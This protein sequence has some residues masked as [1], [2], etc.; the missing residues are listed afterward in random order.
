MDVTETKLSRYVNMDIYGAKPFSVRR[1]HKH[2]GVEADDVY[3]PENSPVSLQETGTYLPIALAPTSG[4]GLAIIERINK[5]KGS[6]QFVVYDGETEEVFEAKQ[7]AENRVE[8][9]QAQARQATPTPAPPKRS[10]RR[11]VSA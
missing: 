6:A 1:R 2:N 7:L 9:L 3:W 10:H 8:H 5:F 11:K 4:H